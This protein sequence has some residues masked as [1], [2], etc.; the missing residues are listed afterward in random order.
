MKTKTR[1][2]TRTGHPPLA[3]H[4]GRAVRVAKP[5]RRKANAGKISTVTLPSVRGQTNA[6]DPS[7]G[8]G[9]TDSAL[10][11]S[12]AISA[13]GIDGIIM[14]LRQLQYYRN[15]MNTSMMRI[16]H[17]TKSMV[18]RA[19]GFGP[20]MF[21]DKNEKQRAKVAAQ[22]SNL[23]KQLWSIPPAIDENLQIDSKA[24][25]KLI[26][27]NAKIPPSLKKTACELYDYTF[28]MLQAYRG[29]EPREAEITRQMRRLASQLPLQSFVGSVPGID[30][31]AIAIIFGEAGN[32]AAYSNPAKLWKRF[33]LAPVEHN[34][35]NRSCSQWRSKGG[36]SKEEWIVVGY[37]PMR[38]SMMFRIGKS[39][40]FQ[41]NKNT[42]YPLYIE[43]K[44]F[45]AA[46]LKE[47]Y[48][49]MKKK[50]C[51]PLKL[52]ADRRAQRYMEKRFLLELWRAWRDAIKGA[53]HGSQ[54]AQ[55]EIAG[56]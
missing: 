26:E 50:E 44:K 51:P 13:D 27:D 17:Q 36:L 29:V 49:G 18:R 37:A 16:S 15:A 23:L 43:R 53:G 14:E 41:G 56:T 42:Y 34:G 38:R 7:A 28:S 25:D 31:L 48:A 21:G 30:W 54:D 40:I 55:S 33:G 4:R 45:E 11:R 20:A 35:Q 3:T 32:L 8:K 5:P 46:K 52:V 19:I 22:A 6:V 39:L 9:H 10:R 1:K 2:T 47:Q 12:D 24:T